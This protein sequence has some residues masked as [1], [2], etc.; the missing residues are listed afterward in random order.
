MNATIEQQPQMP[1]TPYTQANTRWG[2]VWRGMEVWARDGKIGQLI[3]IVRDRRTDEPSHL[4]VRRGRLWWRHDLLVPLHWMIEIAG[5]RVNMNLRMQQVAHL[6]VYRSPEQIQYDVCEQLYT[7][8]VLMRNS[9]FFA[10]TVTV[11]SNVVYLRGAVRDTRHKMLAQSVAHQVQ[12]V[13]E[14]QNE[15]V[16]DMDVEQQIGDVLA[17]AERVNHGDVQAQVAL[18]RVWLRG[19]VPT[20]AVHDWITQRVLNIHGVAVVHDEIMVAAT[21][22]PTQ[23]PTHRSSCAHTAGGNYSPLRRE[24]SL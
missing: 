10:I 1:Q 22:E 3:M 4:V 19:T 24:L 11:R 20:S 7:T 12:G 6:A 16:A 8:P 5:T 2:P 14:V 13:H 21:A 15:L 23:L 9:N 17:R 18:G